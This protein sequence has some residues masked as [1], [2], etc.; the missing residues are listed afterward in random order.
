MCDV[1]QS[2]QLCDRGIGGSPRPGGGGCLQRGALLQRGGIAGYRRSGG[3]GASP[4]RRAQFGSAL[5]GKQEGH[6]QSGPGGPA[7]GG[8]GLRPPDGAGR[9]HGHRPGGLRP[10]G[11]AGGGRTLA[12]WDGTS[13][14]R[15]SADG[16]GG[17]GTRP[18]AGLCA[19]GRRRRGGSGGRAGGLSGEEPGR[20][21]GPSQRGGPAPAV[22]AGPSAGGARGPLSGGYGRHQGPGTREAGGGG[23]R[24]RRPQ[25]PPHWAARGRQDPHLPRRSFHP[26]PDEHRRGAGGDQDLLRQR[27]VAPWNA[28]HP[29]PAVPLSPSHHFSR[30][31]GGR[32]A[33]ASTGR[34]LAGPPGCALPGRTAR[35]RDAR[36]GSTAPAAGGSGGDHLPGLRDAYFPGQFYPDR[37]HEPLSLRLLRR[38]RPRVYLLAGDDRPLPAAPERSTPG[39]H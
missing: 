27:D 33:L 22:P 13:Y 16:L 24:G 36:A 1:G 12:G 29:A 30:R 4:G 37:C 14:Q 39:P 11:S 18:E 5:S 19:G 6:R 7:Q 8:A 28:P 31:A 3:A 23:G 35:V 15:C 38:Y 34:D 9:V 10:G 26:A 25:R 20:A 17:A 21:A 2:D 32:R